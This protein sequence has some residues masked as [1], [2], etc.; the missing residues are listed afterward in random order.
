MA[1]PSL[2]LAQRSLDAAV[3]TLDVNLDWAFIMA[4]TAALQAARALMFSQG[5]RPASGDGQHDVVVQFARLVIPADELPPERL[6][7]FEKLRQDRNRAH[8]DAAGTVTRR[9]AL[10]A[11]D[12]AR[13]LLGVVATRLEQRAP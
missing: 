9:H 5:L 8:Y 3:P 6:A 1:G 7:Y 10:Q 4:Y 11:I 13:E 2:K 12:F